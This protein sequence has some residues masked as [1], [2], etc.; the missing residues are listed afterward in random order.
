MLPRQGGAK[1]IGI[2]LLIGSLVMGRRLV[3]TPLGS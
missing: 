1:I 3:A 2:V